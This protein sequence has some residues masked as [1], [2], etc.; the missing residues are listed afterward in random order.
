MQWGR[1]EAQ[2]KFIIAHAFLHHVCLFGLFPQ[3]AKAPNNEEFVV[4]D[5]KFSNS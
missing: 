1:K 4:R 2:L 3:L 5:L